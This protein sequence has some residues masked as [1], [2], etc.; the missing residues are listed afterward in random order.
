[1]FKT[2]NCLLKLF[3][4]IMFLTSSISA[5]GFYISLKPRIFDVN[6]KNGMIFNEDVFS[7]GLVVIFAD[8]NTNVLCIDLDI[9]SYTSSS[10]QP[11]NLF[12]FGGSFAQ[13]QTRS[14]I[15]IGDEI[16]QAM[17]I[18]L[19]N[20]NQIYDQS[21]TKTDFVSGYLGYSRKYY[22]SSVA[23]YSEFL[24][25][26][27]RYSFGRNIEGDINIENYSLGGRVNF[28]IEY[29]ITNN[30]TIGILAGTNLFPSFQFWRVEFDGDESNDIDIWDDFEYP[31]ISSI[32]ITYGVNLNIKIIN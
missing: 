7:Q 17:N 22:L 31:E 20:N 16:S 21:I 27:H 13:F 1:M 26:I 5:R 2:R 23:I 9:K 15:L 8:C 29:S 30:W 6:V 24:L 14:D 10:S 11:R 4:F 19:L 18:L 3:L 28:G 25:G 12:L 32:G